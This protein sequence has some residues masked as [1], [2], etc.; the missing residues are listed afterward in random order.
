MAIW[1]SRNDVSQG[2]A[3]KMRPSP[4][5]APRCC[6]SRPKIPAT[7]PWPGSP[8]YFVLKNALNCDPS[9]VLSVVRKHRPPPFGD[10]Q[11]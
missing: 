1:V 9:R 10:C 6:I 5:P 7:G 4:T 11:F 2:T 3:V 8:F